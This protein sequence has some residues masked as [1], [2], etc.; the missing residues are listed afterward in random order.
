MKY[1]RILFLCFMCVFA[2][3]T[4]NGQSTAGVD[5]WMAFLQNVDFNMDEM[6][7]LSLTIS[8]DR[9][10]EVFIEN[11]PIGYAEHISLPEHSIK[12]IH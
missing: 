9:E 2:S 7:Y 4:C 3:F 5:F 8:S 12:R 10:S 1:L 11:K 6:H